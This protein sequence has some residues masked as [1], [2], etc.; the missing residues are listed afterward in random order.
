MQQTCATGKENAIPND[1][2][3][4]CSVFVAIWTGIA[5]IKMQSWLRHNTCF[6]FRADEKDLKPDSESKLSPKT[7]S[8]PPGVPQQGKLPSFPGPNYPPVPLATLPP[9]IK[10]ERTDVASEQGSEVKNSAD[11][12]DAKSRDR[13][14]NSVIPP[15]HAPF[16]HQR[17]HLLPPHSQ[18]LNQD[19]KYPLPQLP[20]RNPTPQHLYA[21]SCD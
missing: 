14:E 15:Y 16:Y 12:I 10:V 19:Q 11:R 8:L 20:G 13:L 6:I 3:Q 4:K 2:T 21:V 9:E 17:P 5:S 18:I 1:Q 7:L